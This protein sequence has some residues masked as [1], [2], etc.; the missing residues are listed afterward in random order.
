[1]PPFFFY[2]K[3]T[4]LLRCDCSACENIR[5]SYEDT[6]KS[7]KDLSCRERLVK[8]LRKIFR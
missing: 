8:F 5:M 3:D 7:N 1:M 2:N 4:D 6:P